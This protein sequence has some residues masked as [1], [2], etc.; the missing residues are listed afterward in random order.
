M[1]IQEQTSE[2]AIE[3][4]QDQFQ[5][6]MQESLLETPPKATHELN[7]ATTDVQLP[8]QPEFFK[9]DES[10]NNSV[11]SLGTTV[12]SPPCSPPGCVSPRR[13]PEI[14]ASVMDSHPQSDFWNRDET[15][16][17]ENAPNYANK[18][19]DQFEAQETMEE[20]EEVDEKENLFMPSST[21]SSVGVFGAMTEPYLMGAAAMG[22]FT[23]KPP[24]FPEKEEAVEKAD[25]EINEDV[26][27]EEEE[28]EDEDEEQRRIGHQPSSMVT[29]MSSSQPSEEFQVRSSAFGGSSGW[30]G[31]DP[32]SGMDSEDV[33]SCASSRQQGVSDL[34][35]TQ[36]TAILEGTQSS[37]ALVDSS[38]RGSEGDCNLMGSPNV[39]TLANEEEDDDDDDEDHRVDEMDLSSERAEEHTKAFQ[40]HEHAD[41]ED[42]DIEMRSEGVTESCENAEDDDDFNEDERFDEMGRSGP[43]EALHTSW[44]QN[45]SVN[46]P[47]TEPAP[48]QSVSPHSQVSHHGALESETLSLAQTHFDSFAPLS[49]TKEELDHHHLDHLDDKETKSAA[50]EEDRDLLVAPGESETST[51]EDLRDYDSS[52]GVESRSEKQQTPI[53]ASVQPDLEQDLG[54]HL[55]KGDGEEEE[56]ET[57]PADEL[58]G[59]GPPTA[60]A[61]ATSSPST[62][63]DEASDTEGEMQI[64]YP[65]AESKGFGSP[66][67]A[68]ATHD[69]PALEEDEEVGVGG[70][71][72]ATATAESEE[73]GGGATPQ[74]ANSVASYGFDCTTSNS[75]AHSVAESCGKS[76]GIFSLENEEQLPEEAKDP[77]LIKELTLPPLPVAA[78]QSA[79]GDEEL[80]LLGRH[81][82]LAPLGHGDEIQ[83]NLAEHH[84]TPAGKAAPTSAEQ[85]AEVKALE[86]THHLLA[87]GAGEGSDSQPPYYST[88][89]DKTDSFLAGNV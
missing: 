41:D 40:Q 2:A 65:A 87:Q 81:V 7:E 59:T 22:E 71:A 1:S 72:A 36:H 16:S 63:G 42:E 37:D 31:D 3:S 57:L 4:T 70:Y 14:A 28:D 18:N 61:S 25:E 74:S 27:D 56:A 34:S 50:L 76:P 55:E 89:C 51:P 79:F 19:R 39:E 78:A 10:A 48:L 80:L 54:I 8:T 20:D 85:L 53:P 5:E 82:D 6:M 46:K 83:P 13:E 44:G 84:Y 86:P 67:P 33:S 26:E 12:M 60:P 17:Q 58:L 73:D 88:L 69:L 15:Q 77:S 68:P 49:H 30:L 21:A 24:L 64:N 23:V 66:V 38:F 35:S 47:W 32:L 29:D 45:Q 43:C 11:T 62:S 52:S 9:C 75:N